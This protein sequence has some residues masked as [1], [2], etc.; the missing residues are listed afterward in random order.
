MMVLKLKKYLLVFLSFLVLFTS[1]MT[2]FSVPSA[3]AQDT[4]P[5]YMQTFDQW[6]LKVYDTETSPSQEIFG[7]RYTAAQVTWVI[8][9]LISFFYNA[10]PARLHS[11]IFRRGDVNVCMR[12][13]PLLG[14]GSYTSPTAQK[15][16]LAS[17]FPEDNQLSGVNYVRNAV[18]NISLIPTAQAQVGFGFSALGPIQNIWRIFRDIM[19]GLFVIIIIV[20]AFMIMFRVK[21]NPQTVVTIQSA[22][23]K[24][25]ITLIL[26]TFSYAIAGFLIDLTY[27]V[28]GLVALI[29]NQSHLFGSAD[30]WSRIFELLTSGPG[31]AT[32]KIGVLSWFGVF[33]SGF[34]PAITGSAGQ[35]MGL[36]IGIGVVSWLIGIFIL[37][38]LMIWMIVTAVKVFVLLIKTYVSIFLSVIFSPLIIGF[39]A[40]LPGGGFGGWMKGLVT[41]LAVYPVAGT[42]LMLSVLFLGATYDSVR[43]LLMNRLGVDMVVNIF[44]PAGGTQFWYPPLTLGTQGG[45]WDP[46]PILWVFSALG[47]LSMIPKTADMIKSLMAGKGVESPDLLGK[48]GALAGGLGMAGGFAMRNVVDPTIFKIS[49]G[50]LNSGIGQKWYDPRKIVGRAV[51]GYGIRSGIVQTPSP[52][53]NVR[54]RGTYNP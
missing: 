20:F 49:Q 34:W 9:S 15:S 41:N 10:T 36:N 23:P 47:I 43:T 11:C 21:I 22:I 17:L 16:V 48:G 42:M 53:S 35:I 40:I 18:K 24:I 7:E 2:Y 27:V 13:N 44:N 8:Y 33:M 54:R 46:L 45:T 52:Q 3:S 29:I 19:Y 38:G 50:Y 26:V 31:S 5:W 32:E 6:Y 28:I 4:N 51:T 25:I 12:E 30:Q 37:L 1:S 39:G 14:E